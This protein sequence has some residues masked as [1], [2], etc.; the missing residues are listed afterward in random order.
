MWNSSLFFIFHISTTSCIFYRKNAFRLLNP[1]FYFLT[2]HF[3]Q[4]KKS[5]FSFLRK[6]LQKE[7]K[8]KANKKKVLM[9]KLK[10]Q[11]RKE[12][13]IIT[14]WIIFLTSFEARNE[15]YSFRAVE[16]K[17]Q[18]FKGHDERGEVKDEKRI[19]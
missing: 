3:S 16:K 1:S 7:L 6:T 19:R 2:C 8:N 18:S 14:T 12:W 13:I 4:E 9:L 11:R 5:L 15:K 17:G 10:V